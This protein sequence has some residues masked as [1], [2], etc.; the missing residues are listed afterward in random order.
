M[1]KA[2]SVGTLTWCLRPV[3]PVHLHK[4]DYTQGRKSLHWGHNL[5]L[6]IIIATII[7]I[8]II[9]IIVINVLMIMKT[10]IILCTIILTK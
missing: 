5:E 1:F 2:L 3:S 10:S 7:G 9:I 8:I 4:E 6:L